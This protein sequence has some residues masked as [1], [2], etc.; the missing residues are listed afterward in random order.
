MHGGG[1]W[2]VVIQDKEYKIWPLCRVAIK[3]RSLRIGG[4]IFR[5]F[6]VEIGRQ[7][8]EFDVI[9]PFIKFVYS[10]VFSKDEQHLQP[11]IS[12]SCKDVVDLS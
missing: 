2:G 1:K 10:Q 11:F 5:Q 8:S 4:D 7:V 6:H 3:S 9:S 12:G